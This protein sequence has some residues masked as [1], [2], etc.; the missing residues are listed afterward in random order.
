[1]AHQDQEGNAMAPQDHRGGSQRPSRRT[2]LRDAAGAGAAATALSGLSPAA[3]ARTRTGK[4]DQTA[5]ELAANDSEQFVV[6]VKDARTGEI[7]VFRGTRETRL[8]DRNLAK[9]L[10]R[11]SRR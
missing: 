4:Q 2:V 9:L 3:Y 11:L 1:M 10:D 8:Y 5:D 6:H 7:D